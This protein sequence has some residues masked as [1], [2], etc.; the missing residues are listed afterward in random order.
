MQNGSGQASMH[1]CERVKYD[2]SRP[3]LVEEHNNVCATLVVMPILEGMLNIDYAKKSTHDVR[4]RHQ[5]HAS[6]AKGNQHKLH[7]IMPCKEHR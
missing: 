1:M 4:T 6:S 2:P 5:M 3:E 7:A